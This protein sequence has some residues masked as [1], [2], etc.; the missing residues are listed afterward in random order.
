MNT[1]SFSSIYAPGISGKSLYDLYRAIEQ[2]V[3]ITQAERILLIRQ[4]NAATG[5]VPVSTP[6]AVLLARGLGGTIGYLVSKYFGMGTGGRVASTAL[7]I[8][9][10][11]MIYDQ[12]NKPKPTFPGWKLL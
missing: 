2:D 9:L 6:L 3:S 4:L 7:G 8:G 10:G 12:F 11:K 5:G 1:S